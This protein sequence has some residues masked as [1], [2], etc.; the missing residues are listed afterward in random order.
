MELID[1]SPILVERVYDQIRTAIG[2]CELSPGTRIRQADLADRLGVSRQPVSHALQLLKKDGLVEDHGRKGLRVTPIGPTQ[3]RNLYQ[4]RAALDALAARLAAGRVA[5]DEATAD[6]KAALGAIINEAGS[7]SDATPIGERIDLDI[8]FHNQVV[9]MSGNP[10]IA[11]MLA[12]NFTHM[13]RAMRLVLDSGRLRVSSWEDHEA[14]AVLILAGDEAAGERAFA[15][16]NNAGR[17]TEA[18][19][20]AAE[21]MA[22]S[23]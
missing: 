6:E 10:Q 16:A 20:L 23:A 15:H 18:R 7:F 21:A 8:A 2:T 11:E 3:L 9:A 5:A 14:I 13:M 22:A 17:E 12:P 4:I 19:L 1:Q